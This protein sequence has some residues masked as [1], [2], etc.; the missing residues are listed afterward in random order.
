MIPHLAE[1]NTARMNFLAHLYLARHDD[2]L[3]LGGLVG[4]FVRGRRALKRFPPGVRQGIELHRWIDGQTDQSEEMGRLRELFPGKFRRYAGII[5][6]LAFDHELARR[7]P[8]FHDRPLEAFDRDIRVLLQE[9]RALLPDGLVRFMAYADRRGLFAAYRREDEVLVS[10]AGIG[11]RLRR[12][13]P[14]HRCGE[15]WND[16]RQPCRSGFDDYFPR[17]QGEVD[18]WLNLRSTMTGS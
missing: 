13:N 3:M 15:I 1:Y 14:L 2:E 18:A 8:E 16:I 5:L 4:D 11:R 6:D 12:P 7:W 10:L 9:N 17:L